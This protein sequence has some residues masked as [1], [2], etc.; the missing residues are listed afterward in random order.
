MNDTETK[1]SIWFKKH[2]EHNKQLKEAHLKNAIEEEKTTKKIFEQNTYK[3]S[4][5][6][7]KSYKICTG[8]KKIHNKTRQHWF[9]NKNMEDGLS[10]YCKSCTYLTSIKRKY[11]INKEQLESLILIQDNRCPIC[12]KSFH[13]I[14]RF[15]VDHDHKTKKVRGLLCSHCNSLLGFAKD[16]IEILKKAIKYLES[17]NSENK[18]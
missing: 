17:N 14:K 5:Y 12:N 6:D 1:A 10:I 9:T 13:F 3:N 11:N 7:F 15:C 8:C 2:L 18:E 4:L 16:N